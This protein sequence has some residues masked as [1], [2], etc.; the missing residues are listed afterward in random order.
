MLN[1]FQPK[2]VGKI[3]GLQ[4]NTRLI[5]NIHKLSHK[6]IEY[7]MKWIAGN[8]DRQPPTVLGMAGHV[9]GETVVPNFYAR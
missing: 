1:L 9:G 6:I 7:R 3:R 4:E 5:D 2:P 8:L